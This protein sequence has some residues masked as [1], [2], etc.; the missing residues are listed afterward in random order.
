MSAKAKYRRIIKF[1][2]N[3]YSKHNFSYKIISTIIIALII[4]MALSLTYDVSEKNTVLRLYLTFDVCR[5]ESCYTAGDEVNISINEIFLDLHDNKPSIGIYFHSHEDLGGKYLKLYSDSYKNNI[6]IFNFNKIKSIS[7]SE[8]SVDPEKHDFNISNPTGNEIILK[9]QIPLGKFNR[10]SPGG[11][12]LY[13][14]FDDKLDYDKNNLTIIFSKR[15]NNVVSIVYDDTLFSLENKDDGKELANGQVRFEKTLDS[16]QSYI[17]LR[18]KKTWYFYLSLFVIALPMS[19]VLI[20]LLR[21]SRGAKER[22]N[23]FNNNAYLDNFKRRYR[24]F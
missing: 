15:A 17:Y 19:T 7:I 4:T 9:K 5:N 18:Y 8:S 22:K 6:S 11:Y 16:K 2:I 3:K 24:R 23:K 20:G 12:W 1:L 13:I 14:E 21:N 10:P